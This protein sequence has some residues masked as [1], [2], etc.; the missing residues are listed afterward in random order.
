MSQQSP[1]KV[2]VV[3]R[4]QLPPEQLRQ[5][6]AQAEEG[7]LDDLWLWE[8]CFLEGGFT[9]AA[10][11][12]AWSDTVRVGIGLLPVPL[13]NPAVSAMEIAV[14]GR[15]FPGR[16]V[17]A[18]GHGVLS[19][20]EQ[21]GARVASPLTLLREWV[22]AT[23]SLLHGETVNVDGEYVRLRQVALDWPPQ[24]APPLLIGG[25]GPKTL[26]LAG[27]VSDGLVLDAGITPALVQNAIAIATTTD[28]KIPQEV[29]TY[30]H[31]GS[32]PGA[33]DRLASEHAYYGPL[34]SEAAAT[35][36]PEEVA[37]TIHAYGEAG[38]TTVALQPAGDDPDVAATIDLAVKAR[39]LLHR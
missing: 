1:P 29:I 17:P 28:G 9:S 39:S 11:A 33:F 36:S 6:V 14:L 31:C 5:Y 23:R 20:M 19:W 34:T 3:F 37:A 26:A 27:E 35:G 16:F 10:V 8:D 22:S 24:Q 4:P 38:A 21:V 30:V 25:R 32:G 13:R 18:A 7:Q 15:L 2:G 12:L